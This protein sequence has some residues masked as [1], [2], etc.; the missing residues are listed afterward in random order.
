M[1]ARIKTD[2]PS[3][4]RRTS[5]APG[6]YLGY[7]LQSTR[8]L[9]RLLEADRDWFVS[10]EVFDDVGVQTSRG[11]IIA[12][13]T[14]S[15]LKGNPVYDRAVDLWKTF[16]NWVDAVE[17]G[18]LDIDKSSFEIYV[19]QP[20]T[21]QIV[22]AFSKAKTVE[23]ALSAIRIAKGILWGPAP[24]YHLKAS[25]AKGIRA[26]VD[27]VFNT[28]ERVSRIIASFT[29]SC[30]SGSSQQDL[31]LLMER[32]L[33]IQPELIDDVLKYALGW[34]KSE[35]DLL[36]EQGK[37]AIIS[38]QRF[39]TNL[40][41]FVQKVTSKAILMTFAKD[42]TPSQIASDLR[43]RMYVR[44]LELIESG[45][46]DKIRAVTDFLKASSDRTNWSERGLVH[47][48][49]FDDFEEGLVRSWGNLKRKTDISLSD[50]GAI[51]R[52]QYL[53]SECSEHEA[54]LEGLEVPKHFVPG[55]FHALSDSQIVGWH[56]EYK[57][58]LGA[59]HNKKR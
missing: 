52:G 11:H 37:P 15:S 14:K 33:I 42:P 22:E 38:V 32:K 10:L 17:S 30:G 3:A 1:G 7:S 43:L 34:V 23:E 18:Q 2:K 50:R 40:L 39:R 45:D 46:G 19:A 56:P 6:Q 5:Q 13:Q 35:T 28:E 4:Q 26:Y 36:L 53:Y 57:V 47:E 16:S 44:Q 20:K 48:S 25:V 27:R 21:G 55:S 41:G 59:I 49:S 51:A 9:G 58:R 54:K 31:R 8:F 24:Q 12:E 29:Y